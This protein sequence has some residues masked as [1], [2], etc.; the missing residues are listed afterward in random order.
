MANCD[1]H[2]LHY[3]GRFY[4]WSNKQVGERRVMSKIDRVL[5]NDHREET[6]PNA[7]VTF[8]PEGTYDHSSILVQFSLPC[9]GL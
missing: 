4:T 8:L 3:N 7:V 2:D 9:R 5:G 6:F 1:I